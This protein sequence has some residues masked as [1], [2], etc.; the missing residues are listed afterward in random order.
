M[1]K[2]R[3]SLTLDVRPGERVMIGNQLVEIELVHKS[4]Q[5]ARIKFTAPTEVKI[6]LLKNSSHQ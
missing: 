4:G 6:E 2:D 3:G 5:H 1:S